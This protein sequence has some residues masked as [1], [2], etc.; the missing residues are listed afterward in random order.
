MK[1]LERFLTEELAGKYEVRWRYDF[2][3]N[4]IITEMRDGLLMVSHTNSMDELR[5]NIGPRIDV[6]MVYIL[7][8]M[9]CRIDD[10]RAKERRTE[11]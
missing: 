1:M 7:R 10:Y 2:R 8:N 5:H 6:Y 11:K 3:T 9:M 4:S